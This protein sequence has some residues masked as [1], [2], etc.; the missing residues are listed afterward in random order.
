MP[1][2]RCTAASIGRGEPALG[3]ASTVRA[4]LLVENAG[5][6]GVDALRDARLPEQV[7]SGLRERAARAGVRVLLVRRHGSVTG[8]GIR[9]FAAYADPRRPWLE[10]TMIAESEVLLDLDLRA[11]GRGDSPGLTRTTEPVF[12]VC[13][14]GRHD[15]CCAELG[16]PTAA[17][18]AA[19]HPELTW[20]VSHIGGDRFAANL[21][22]LPDGLYYGRVPAAAAPALAARHLE[23]HLDLDLLRGR[24]GF[25]FAVQ[26]AEV[27][28]RR[29]LGD[30][31]VDAV[32]LVSLV[33][34]GESCTAVLESGG[35]SYEVLVRREAE[36]DTHLL[37]CR[38][39]R[40]NPVPRYRVVAISRES[41]GEPASARSGRPSPPG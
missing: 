28:L 24:S 21:L 14:H 41:A 34:S 7:K 35:T 1:R 17:A 20:E 25:P 6:W 9:V 23:G 32:R 8:T 16:R 31:R 5:P 3:S 10:T 40:E 22:V 15:A 11:L 19:S 13:T 39:T 18:L 29:E 37:T 2:F 27:A 33:Q 4:F 12:C 26:V 30:T 36:E 38:A